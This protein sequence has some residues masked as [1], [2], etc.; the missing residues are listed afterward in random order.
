MPQLQDF[1]GKCDWTGAMTLLEF[2]RRADDGDDKT[3]LWMAYCSFHLGDYAKALDL[4]DEA[5][6]AHGPSMDASLGRACCMYF[7]GRP[8]DAISIA[9]EFEDES[10]L[11]ARV[12]FH[13]ALKDGDEDRLLAAHE[14]I[15]D[16]S[17]TDQLSLAALHYMRS[18]FQEAMEIF[19]RINHDHKEDI[20]LHVYM[21]M[22]Y[23]KLDY[24]DVS[25]KI[26]QVYLQHSP[27][28]PAAANL[29]ACNHFRL[30]NGKAAESELRQLVDAT[31]DAAVVED[32]ATLKHNL[33]IFRG[34]ADA[35]RILTP[36]LD[37][38]P[39]ARL[40]LTIH[41][42]KAGD[43]AAA[44]ATAEGIKPVAPTEYIV[45]AVVH[46]EL[47][48]ASGDREHLRLAQQY[49]QLGET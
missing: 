41:Y 47:G 16:T 2:Q 5:I 31:G 10:P 32:S 22:C 27:H 19:K 35:S 48:Q 46:A 4:Y 15:D 26:L 11:A 21:A 20:A 44:H 3:L 24:Y 38:V 17:K 14:K 30:Y 1:V 49:F 33:C 42:L 29:K 25:L 6:E 43:I 12:I 34:G 39:E 40:N 28:S 7:L 36:L 23:Y 37:S 9:E 8:K 45:K 18:H 13:A